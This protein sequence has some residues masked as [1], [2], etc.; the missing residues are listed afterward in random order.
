[1]VTGPVSSHIYYFAD[2]SPELVDNQTT[3]I[4]RLDTLNN[5]YWERIY[6]YRAGSDVVQIDNKEVFLY[7]TLAELSFAMMQMDANTGDILKTIY[8]KGIK[9]RGDAQMTVSPD[10]TVVYLCLQNKWSF[11]GNLCR[12]LPATDRYIRCREFTALNPPKTITAIDASH[13]Y[14]V[15]NNYDYGAMPYTDT[16]L[17]VTDFFGAKDSFTNKIPCTQAQ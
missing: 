14:A 10:D 17:I 13:A 9:S 3:Y 16:Y 7:A 6:M 1:M 15:L 5:P 4:A 2:V 12:W 8:T 11:N